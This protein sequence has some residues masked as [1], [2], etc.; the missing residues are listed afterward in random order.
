MKN[1]LSKSRADDGA[2]RYGDEIRANAIEVDCNHK[3]GGLGLALPVAND[4][5]IPR[6]Q[7]LKKKKTTTKIR[8]GDTTTTSG[9]S[10]ISKAAIPLEKESDNSPQIIP[11]LPILQSYFLPFIHTYDFLLLHTSLLPIFSTLVC[12]NC[13]LDEVNRKLIAS[14]YRLLKVLLIPCTL[15]LLGSIHMVLQIKR[16]VVNLGVMARSI[17]TSHVLLSVLVYLY[18]ASCGEVSGVRNFGVVLMLPTVIL[19]VPD[20]L[21][22]YLDLF[23]IFST[24]GTAS[25]LMDTNNEDDLSIPEYSTIS[26][27]GSKGTNTIHKILIN[28]IRLPPLFAAYLL[29]QDC[30]ASLPN[31]NI[32]DLLKVGGRGVLVYLYSSIAVKSF[33]GGMFGSRRGQEEEEEVK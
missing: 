4:D 26:N 11:I 25:K 7:M 16:K 27:D 8:E 5:F 20:L 15:R 28:M 30:I 19:D 33:V 21:I 13:N 9:R 29:L 18:L 14:N 31:T 2:L 12:A 10:T 22:K 32:T 17:T 6:V 1:A 3:R 23:S 24:F